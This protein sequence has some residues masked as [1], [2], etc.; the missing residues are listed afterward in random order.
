MG[1]NDFPPPV[2]SSC[3]TLRG[4][5][6]SYLSTTHRYSYEEKVPSHKTTSLQMTFNISFYFRIWEHQY[7][8]FNSVVWYYI[9]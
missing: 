8:C 6:H 5:G 7:C 2:T 3:E 4:N 1:P 9:E